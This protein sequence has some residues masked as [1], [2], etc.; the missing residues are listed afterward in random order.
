MACLAAQPAQQQG[1]GGALLFRRATSAQQFKWQP[2]L[3]R[4]AD[5][6][7]AA[8]SVQQFSWQLDLMRVAQ[9]LGTGVDRMQAVDPDD[10]SDS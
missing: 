9:S 7:K 1:P 8:S 10:A 2:D 6:L 4:A 3:M 5:V